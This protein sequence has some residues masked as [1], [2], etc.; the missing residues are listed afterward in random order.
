MHAA[1]SRSMSPAPIVFEPLFM[2]RI[3]GGRRLES[4]YGK[5]LPIGVRI[6]ESWELVDR[7]DY[8]SVVH[9]G[10]LRGRVLN[11]LWLK[12]RTEI[13]GEGLE[14]TPRFPLL[15]KL[16]DCQDRL[17]VQVHPPAE[18][19]ARFGGE[20]KTEMWYLLDALLDSDIYAGLRQGVTRE[21]FDEALRAGHVADLI[22]R[23]PSRT[24]DAYFMPSGRIHAIGAGNVIFEVQQ[25]SDTTY[26]VF[27]WNRLGL[28]GKPRELHICESLASIDFTDAEPT[29]VQPQGE[30]VVRC[31]YFTV[32]R[33]EIDG[34]RQ[35]G[36]S[37][38]FAVFAV[39]SGT[40]ECGGHTFTVGGFFLVPAGADLMLTGQGVVL[41]TT[42]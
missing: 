14:D 24:G 33:W 34:E 7:A 27:D 40:I 6:G 35:S 15:F 39:E 41:R 20:T 19:A 4:S 30:T 5:R 11:D 38:R 2:E 10:P 22:H 26:R 29:P 18:A 17:S 8:Q 31:E 25:N 37:S 9:D 36:T 12:N 32:E 1:I 13:F 21:Q 28:D 16:L 3:W 23:I 42:I